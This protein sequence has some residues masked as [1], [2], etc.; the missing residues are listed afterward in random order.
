MCFDGSI[1]SK[2]RHNSFTLISGFD[3]NVDVVIDR[4]ILSPEFRLVLQRLRTEFHR[5]VFFPSK[6]QFGDPLPYFDLVKN[7]EEIK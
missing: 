6:S 3:S 2:V 5:S 1:Q 7:V 4:V